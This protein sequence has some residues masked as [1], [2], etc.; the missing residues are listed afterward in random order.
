MRTINITVAFSLLL[1]FGLFQG[2][3]GADQIIFRPG[4]GANDGSDAGGANGGKDTYVYESQPDQN[5]GQEVSVYSAGVSNCNDTF[6]KGYLQFDVSSL[7]AE[8]SQVYLGVTHYPHTEHCYSNCDLNYYFYPISQAWDEVTVTYNTQPTEGAALYGPVN[9]TFPNDFGTREYDITDIYRSWKTGTLD[10]YGLAFFSPEV[11]CNNGAVVFRFHSS[12]DTDE[13]LR[14][15]L[16]VI[17]SGAGDDPIFAD[18][19]E[20]GDTDSW[21]SVMP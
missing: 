10:N 11:G 15:Y 16:R 8:V 2:I 21:S 7:P 20:N 12:D 9:I 1:V 18:G 4:P 19:F 13:A 3:A 6:A 14:P 5:L 17:T